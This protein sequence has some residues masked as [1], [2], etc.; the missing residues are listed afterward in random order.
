MASISATGANGHHTF[1][2]NVN[3]TYVSGGAENY[4]TVSWSFQ[5]SGGSSW[6]FYTIGST[7]TITINGT[8]V[9][10]QYAQRDF[11]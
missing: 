11:N 4:S 2:L 10:N 1:T 9:Y 5:I 3:E 6:Q 7:I 8:T